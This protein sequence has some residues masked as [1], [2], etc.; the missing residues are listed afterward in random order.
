MTHTRFT[1]C[2]TAD[3]YLNSSI[4]SGL[5]ERPRLN[6]TVKKELKGLGGKIIAQSGMAKVRVSMSTYSYVHAKI[7]LLTM[8]MCMYRSLFIVFFFILFEILN[9]F[10]VFL[11][12]NLFVFVCMYLYVTSIGSRWDDWISFGLDDTSE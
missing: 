9:S 3:L 8:Y 6:L 12:H 2:R 11:I 7:L 10:Y 1:V 4:G 5:K